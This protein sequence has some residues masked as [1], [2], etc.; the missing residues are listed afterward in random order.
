VN[1]V[2]SY[3]HSSEKNNSCIRESSY[4][5]VSPVKIKDPI[6]TIEAAR[7]LGVDPSTLRHRIRKGKLESVKAGRDHMVS[8]RVIE[9]EANQKP[10]SVA[11][12]TS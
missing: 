8:R 2:N 7:I 6:T 12:A 3:F 5:K 4:A 9:A 10:A 11:I 1:R